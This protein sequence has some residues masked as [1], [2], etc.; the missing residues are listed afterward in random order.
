MQTMFQQDPRV[1]TFDWNNQH[2]ACHDLPVLK[3]R[4]SVK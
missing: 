3:Q 2:D 1:I 4:G